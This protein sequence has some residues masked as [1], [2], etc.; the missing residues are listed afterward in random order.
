MN[1]RNNEVDELARAIVDRVGGKGKFRLQVAD[2][3]TL[4]SAEV[5]T[6]LSV[7]ALLSASADATDVEV[8]LSWV[9]T[10]HEVKARLRK[11]V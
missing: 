5:G 1:D 7:M 9:S 10:G 4:D 6:L 8:C 2:G 11:N 3:G